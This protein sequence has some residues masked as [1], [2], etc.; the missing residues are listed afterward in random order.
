M[1]SNKEAVHVSFP[2]TQ[3]SHTPSA[4][5]AEISMVSCIS[6]SL[7]NELTLIDEQYYGQLID[8]R[9]KVSLTGHMNITLE[10]QILRV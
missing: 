8:K 2:A 10:T 7:D 3:S 9:I 4:I 5:L 6:L 1:Q